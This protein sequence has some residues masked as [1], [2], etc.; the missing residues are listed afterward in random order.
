[1]SVFLAQMTQFRASQQA[2]D[3]AQRTNRTDGQAAANLPTGPAEQAGAPAPR[4]GTPAG[5][6][7]P[8]TNQPAPTPQ[9]QALLRAVD[10]LRNPPQPQPPRHPR[11]L[12]LIRGGDAQ[13]SRGLGSPPRPPQIARGL[14]ARRSRRAFVPLPRPPRR[15][16]RT[17]PIGEARLRRLQ[18]LRDPFNRLT[19]KHRRGT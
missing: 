1:M 11:I 14:L 16:R 4:E 17:R 15:N 18:A 5:H 10:L 3:R 13:P 19:R 12:A 2:R 7:R 8:Q 6:G 9:Q